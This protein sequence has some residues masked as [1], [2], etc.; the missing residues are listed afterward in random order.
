MSAIQTDCPSDTSEV[1][2][3]VVEAIRNASLRNGAAL[4]SLGMG[5]CVVGQR[6][7]VS[8]IRQK[9]SLARY[10]LEL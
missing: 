7:R 2:A 3:I 8:L 10:I 1:S 4:A 5:S 6:P 9:P